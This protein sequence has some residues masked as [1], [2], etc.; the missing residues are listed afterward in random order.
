MFRRFQG[1]RWIAYAVRTSLVM[2]LPCAFL[3]LSCVPELSPL[4][5]FPG[6][7]CV[8]G[9]QIQYETS[10]SNPYC[11]A[12]CPTYQGIQDPTCVAGCWMPHLGGIVQRDACLRFPSVVDLQGMRVRCVGSAAAGDWVEGLTPTAGA[13]SSCSVLLN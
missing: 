4:V 12:A 11:T 5:L 8:S 7:S 6:G 1:R 9:T 13:S 10:W 2:V 3:S